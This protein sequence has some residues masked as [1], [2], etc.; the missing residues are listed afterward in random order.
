MN[1]YDF[2]TPRDTPPIERIEARLLPSQ[3]KHGL[4]LHHTSITGDRLLPVVRCQAGGAVG[5]G[6]APPLVTFTGE[7]AAGTLG[8]V[9]GFAP[10]LVGLTA[11]E[12]LER[13]HE[14][15]SVL[16]APAKAAL[17]IALHDLL[18]N[19]RHAPVHS[20]LAGEL[21]AGEPLH[22]EAALSVRVSRAIG[23]HSLEETVELS[24]GYL[25]QGIRALKLKVGRD[26]AADAEV[27]RAVRSEV[28]ADIELA[29]DANEAFTADR[30]IALV[31]ACRDA[32]L[33]Y[34]EQPVPRQEY[35]GLRLV[36]EAGIRVMA[37]ESLFGAE[38]A[39]QLLATEAADLFAI[40]LIK[41]GGL[42]PAL[43]I[44]RIA[45]QHGVP[46][47][48]IDPLGSAV[49]L[50]AGLHLAAILQDNRYAHG[51]SAGLDVNSPHAQHLPIVDGHLPL[52]RRSGLGIDVQWPD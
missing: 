4:R 20:L 8:Q 21:P 1:A 31:D 3:L 41:C 38:D 33:A 18:A 32:E 24:R 16:S 19:I 30:A 26:I 2:S 23:F 6:E 47:V 39:R 35:A 46:V 48:V 40:K 13:V 5:H 12:A 9:C 42:R 17:D 44:V 22:G 28:G 36:R 43:D 14:N 25:D 27:I 29:I 37:D 10:Q 11:A 45:R 34:F 51:L 49:S 15:G 7:D 50:N 52:P